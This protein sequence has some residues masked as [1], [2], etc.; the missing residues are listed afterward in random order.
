VGVKMPNNIAA[1]PKLCLDRIRKANSLQS[2]ADLRHESPEWHIINEREWK[3]LTDAFESRRVFLKE[4]IRIYSMTTDERKQYINTYRFYENIS[5]LCKF[6]Q[7]V[8]TE[9]D[10][11]LE[12]AKVDASVDEL[13]RRSLAVTAY[14]STHARNIDMIYSIHVSLNELLNKEIM[15]KVKQQINEMSINDLRQFLLSLGQESTIAKKLYGDWCEHSY[16][17][18]ECYHL[19][20]IQYAH[21]TEDLMLKKYFISIAAPRG[22]PMGKISRMLIKS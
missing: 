13:M 17:L 3:I 2:L 1:D 15:I 8:Q 10:A 22:M 12:T 19:A 11:G 21:H 18:D 6:A 4:K 9:V 16:T 14:L 7:E 5:S 20:I